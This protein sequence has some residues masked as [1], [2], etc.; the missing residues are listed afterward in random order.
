VAGA[1]GYKHLHDPSRPQ[2]VQLDLNPGSSVVIVGANG[3]GKTRLGTFIEFAVGKDAHR[4]PAQRS[5]TMMERTTV[6]DYETS[7]NHLHTGHAS[8]STDKRSQRWHNKPEV[9]AI[10]D[11][12]H[13]IRALFAEKNRALSDDHEKR[14]VGETPD[15]VVTK[16]DKLNEVWKSI[17]PNRDLVFK[18]ASI[19]VRPP[20]NPTE[21]GGDKPYSPSDM[22][23][24]ERVIFYLIGQCMLAPTNG[25]FIVDEPELHIHHSISSA[26]WDAL[27]RER[28]DLAFVYITHDIDFATNRVSA[29]KFFV[30]SIQFNSFYEIEPIPEETGLP[31]DVVLE[32]V[33]NRKSVLFVEG[34]AGSIDTLIYRSLYQH[35]KIEP[36]G[37]CDNVIHSVASYRANPTL[38]RLG[39]VFGCVDADQRSAEEISELRRINIHAIPVA[40]IENVF[41]LPNVFTAITR[42]LSYSR[43]EAVQKLEKVKDQVFSL[44]SKEVDAVVARFTARQIDRK[45][46]RLTIDKADAAA[47]VS[48]YNAAVL[49]IDVEAIASNFKNQFDEAIHSKN[50]ESLLTMYD[51]K[52][53]LGIVA[54][55]LGQ[56]SGKA[57]VTLVSRL[58]QD[59]KH[60]SLKDE[61]LK[62]L[63]SPS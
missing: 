26:L 31:E 43:S 7:I 51:Q 41:L 30:R 27:E 8:P 5:I 36:R 21:Y 17:L 24:G 12:E 53:L 11:F 56:K 48:S 10:N 59:N 52:G 39:G 28:S 49:S 18:D 29:K 20:P 45:L 9:A 37:S 54:S 14:K 42:A 4:I 50:I 60:Q 19:S 38:H 16:L 25:V 44:A 47:L 2:L 1:S 23:D 15:L 34:I 32:L 62:V 13:L 6:L 46:K 33:G 40:E 3:A 63:P 55:E 58:L 35:L 61:V 57:L 22:S